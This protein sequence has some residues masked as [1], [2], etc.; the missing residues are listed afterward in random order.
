M[1]SIS[2]CFALIFVIFLDNMERH[3]VTFIKYVTNEY[4]LHLLSDFLL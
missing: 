4:S 1:L 3:E 2:L